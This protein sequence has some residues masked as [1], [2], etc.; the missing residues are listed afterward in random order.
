MSTKC[1]FISAEGTNLD[2]P[3]DI[4]QGSSYEEENAIRELDLDWGQMFSAA[5]DLAAISWF[6]KKNPH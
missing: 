6:W 5:L 4:Y 3:R 2:T 1:P